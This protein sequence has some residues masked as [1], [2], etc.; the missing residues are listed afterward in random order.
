MPTVLYAHTLDKVAHRPQSA[1][2]DSTLG[3]QETLEE[4]WGVWQE[5][6]QRNWDG[7]DALP[8]EQETYRSAYRLIESLPLGFPRPAIGAEADG[9]L[10]LEWRKSARRTISVSVD[11]AG[12]L[13]FAG[14]YG[15]D[16]RYGSLAYFDSSVVPRELIRLVREL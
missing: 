8:V 6:S 15:C 12:Y 10:T 2:R 11:P 4:L 13:H 1:M 3:H 14:V 5:C 16:R 7:F 9:Q